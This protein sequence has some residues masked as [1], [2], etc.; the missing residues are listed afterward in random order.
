MFC[1]GVGLVDERDGKGVGVGFRFGS[2]VG[3]CEDGV[4]KR[5]EV[6]LGKR[7][8]G[9]GEGAFERVT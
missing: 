6:G 1:G 8:G 4:I 5:A 3:C 2:R 7:E 9:P